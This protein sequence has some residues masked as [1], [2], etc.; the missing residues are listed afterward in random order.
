MT[1]PKPRRGDSNLTIPKRYFFLQWNFKFF[2]NP[3]YLLDR[4]DEKN[5]ALSPQFLTA[6]KKNNLQNRS[7]KNR[8]ADNRK[9]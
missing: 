7:N 9:V 5:L 4:F 2:Q 8:N 3:I 6:N 1:V